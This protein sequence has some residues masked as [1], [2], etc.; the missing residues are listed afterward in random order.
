M[1]PI[2][3]AAEPR[4]KVA[5]LYVAGFRFPRSMPEVDPF[6]FVSRVTIPGPH[7]ERPERPVLP[8]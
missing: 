2:A 1:A 5:V 6:N 3:L 4:F 7:A 8:E